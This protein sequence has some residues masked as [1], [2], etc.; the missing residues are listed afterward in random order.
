MK[1]SAVKGS[2]VKG[3]KSGRTAKGIMGGEV[4]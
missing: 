1:G 3:G 4:K 2:A